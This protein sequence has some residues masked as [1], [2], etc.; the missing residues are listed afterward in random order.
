VGIGLTAV[1][2]RYAIQALNRYLERQKEA[3]QLSSDERRQA[4]G[5]D[6]ALARWAKSVCPGCERAVDLKNEANDYC[7]HCG[8]GLHNRCSQC[9]TRKSAFAK[10]CHACGAAGAS[11]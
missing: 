6:L 5:Y 10:F 9:N 2:G 11:A 8:I 1:I 7:A 4:L 3:E